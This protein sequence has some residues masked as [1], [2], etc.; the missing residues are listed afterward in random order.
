MDKNINVEW[1]LEYYRDTKGDQ[2][3]DDDEIFNGVVDKKA[4]VGK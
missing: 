4:P 2:V 3:P 1:A